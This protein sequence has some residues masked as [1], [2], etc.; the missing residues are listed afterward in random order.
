MMVEMVINLIKPQALA[1]LYKQRMESNSLIGDG[2]VRPDAT[3]LGVYPITNSSIKAVR[4]LDFSG[5]HEGFAVV[6]GAYYLVNSSLF[7]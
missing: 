6:I 3:A 2:S 1:N 4:E 5:E 7:N